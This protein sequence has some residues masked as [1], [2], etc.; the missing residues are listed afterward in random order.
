MDRI[1]VEQEMITLQIGR[2]TKVAAATIIPVEQLIIYSDARSTPNWWYGSKELYALLISTSSGLQAIDQNG[3][4]L[5]IASLIS[6][7]PKLN[8]Y[9]PPKQTSP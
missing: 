5:S 2:V 6:I 4:E 1:Q 9:L 8:E 7:V 3:R